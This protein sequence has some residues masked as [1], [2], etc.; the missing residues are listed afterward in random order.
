MEK[1]K[2]FLLPLFCLLLSGCVHNKPTP[3]SSSS[4]NPSS[5]VT[6]S[7]SEN[8]PSEEPSEDPSET[9]SED[10]SE[11]SSE[12][13]SETSSED[14]SET[15]SEDPSSE[16]PTS[17]SIENNAYLNEASQGLEIGE[18]FLLEVIDVPEGI[19]PEWSLDGDSV[20]YEF[21]DA[22]TKQSA[23]ITGVKSGITTVIVDVGEKHLTCMVNV[24]LPP[25]PLDTPEFS[26]N[27]AGTGIKWTA[28]TGALKYVV[29]INDGT[30]EETTSTEHLFIDTVGEYTIKV[31][32]IAGSGYLDSEEASYTYTTAVTSL[33]ELSCADGKITWTSLGGACAQYHANDDEYADVVGNY[34]TITEPGEQYVRAKPGYKEST[35][36]FYI[37][38]ESTEKTMLGSPIGTD[39]YIEKGDA[40]NTNEL[41]EEYTITYYGSGWEPSTF[42]RVFV[43]N[44][45][46]EGYTSG[47]CV[48]ARY[49]V[50]GNSFK[51]TKNIELDGSFDTMKITAKGDGNAVVKLQLQVTKATSLYGVPLTGIYATYTLGAIEAEW[52]T[53]TIKMMDENWSINVGSQ[54]YKP[55]E[56]PTKLATY[57][58]KADSYLDLIPCFDV[59]SF[60]LQYNGGSGAESFVYL[61]DFMLTNSEAEAG[62]E[63][64]QRQVALKEEYA[65]RTDSMHGRA[66][67]SDDQE[68]AEVF[69]DNGTTLTA[70]LAIDQEN[71]RL[72]VS[73]DE[74]NEDFVLTL[75]TDDYGY[76]WE[77]LSCE[78]S[79]AG[80]F[81]NAVFSR[82]KLLDDF[83]TYEETGDGYDGNTWDIEGRNGLRGAYYC[84]YYSGGSTN[85]SA[86][87]GNGWE[88]MT[89]SDYLQLD[90]DDGY[91]D[92]NCGS[93]KSSSS[94]NMRYWSFDL[95]LSA[96][97]EGP[98]PEPM[99]SGFKKLSIMAKGSPD[100]DVKI[101]MFGFT[102]KAAD[103]TNHV[104]NT[105]RIGTTVIVPQGSDWAE[106]TV[107]LDLSKT[108]YGFYLNVW[109]DQGDGDKKPTHVLIDDICF[110]DDVS[111]YGA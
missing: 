47:N 80:L 30:P 38:D 7:S 70:D 72:I 81:D 48:K 40:R 103:H 27:D 8:D 86:V 6:P 79:I 93:F 68:T 85:P 94:A 87:G 111:P 63:I 53:Y 61:D 99:G 32:A 109:P 17:I 36:T 14:P 108:Y 45:Q 33:G 44:V 43:D 58:V 82:M 110:Y 56:V 106:Y 60:L 10:P 54:G 59:C 98:G 15:S 57:N 73:S 1:R 41:R 29:Q 52:K 12:D 37:E 107:E 91:M 75:S 69:L 51:F 84:D 39:N 46:N 20:S 74:E 101:G 24:A 34:A 50:N 21:T 28:I 13:P 62:E 55:S 77:Y 42:A 92:D 3:S 88:L 4:E 104:D 97:D 71:Q 9:S 16:D 35:R 90:K 11:T 5:E 19:I 83:T 31:T 18:Y 76:S 95:A 67:V 105:V 78:G 49:C 96:L 100:R 65:F 66:V 102:A 89:S 2:L 22:S 23:T 25:Q 64:I 26:V